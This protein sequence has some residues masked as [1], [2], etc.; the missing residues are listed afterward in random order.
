MNPDHFLIAALLSSQGTREALEAW[1][2][3]GP[4]ARDIRHLTPGD[5]DL[6]IKLKAILLA[7]D[8]YLD[9]SRDLQGDPDDGDA[10]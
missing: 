2:E 4:V 5:Q 10:P 9:A 3:S 6:L 1:C 7:Q 8:Q